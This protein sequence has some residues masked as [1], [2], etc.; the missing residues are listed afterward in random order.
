MTSNQLLLEGI[1]VIEFTHVWSGPYCG[2]VLADLGAEVIKVESSMHVDVH[3]RAGPYPMGLSGINRSGVWNAQNRGKFGCTINIR[4]KAGAEIALRLICLAD[5]VI[6]NFAPGV[7]DRR[8]LSF[9][10]MRAIKSEIVL[11]SLTGFGLNGPWRDYPAYGPM[12]DAIGGMARATPSSTGEPQSVNGW[13][14]DTSAALFGA[15]AAIHGI[16]RARQTGRGTHWDIAQ[17]EATLSLLPEMVALDSLGTTSHTEEWSISGVFGCREPDTW[18]WVS[19]PGLKA[20]ERLATALN[21]PFRPDI[22]IHDAEGA[23]RSRL[24]AIKPDE[25]AILSQVAGVEMV[26][27]MSARDLLEDPY[28]RDRGT[29]LSVQ[30]PEVGGMTTYAPLVR[31]E[32]W[33]PSAKLPAPT[34]GQHNDYV[35]GQ[36]LGMSQSEIAELA[37]AKVIA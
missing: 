5:A 34:L 21:I 12:L 16:T 18:V 1:R 11:I 22:S 32:G 36:L 33:P 2:Q 7:L 4:S 35:F 8:G 19:I 10:A 23:L 24:A 17:L 29:F 20:W 27:V 30:H 3:R 6:E 26:P 9:D 28:L 14:P 37:A 31:H 15:L 13:L 25:A